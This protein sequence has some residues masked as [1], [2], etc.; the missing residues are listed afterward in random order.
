[1]FSVV[2]CFRSVIFYLFFVSLQFIQPAILRARE[3][4]RVSHCANISERTRLSVRYTHTLTL[5]VC[6]CVWIASALLNK[7]QSILYLLNNFSR[8]CGSRVRA[9]LPGYVKRR[10]SPLARREG[11]LLTHSF[12]TPH[13][14]QISEMQERHSNPTMWAG[15]ARVCRRG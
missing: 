10:R 3:C 4:R 15:N 9:L 14:E 7:I 2:S 12:N 8:R 6:V 11:W 5:C 1:M 13:N